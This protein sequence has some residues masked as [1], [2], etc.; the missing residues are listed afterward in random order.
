MVT[1]QQQIE[2]LKKSWAEDSRWNG[3][4][5][6]YAAEDV[7][8]LR[9]SVQI[10]YTLA[11]R[12]A[13]RLFRSIHERDFVNALGALTGN[14]AVQQVK[15]GLQAIYLSGWQVAA[16]ANS[17]GQMYPDQSLY[18]VDSV[19]NVVKKINQAL[20][21]AD[22]IDNVEG[23]EGFDWF[24]PIVA[25]AE[26]GFGGPLNVFE[27]MKSMIEA[28][29]AG[30]HFEDQLASEKKCGHLGGKVLQPTQNAV[31]N[32][33]SARLASDV[34]G[35]PTVLIARTDADAADLITSDID[36]VDHPFITGER[37]PEGF[38][39]TNAG[40]DQAIARGLAYAPYADLVW[41]ET[42][43]PNL[44]EAQQFADAIHEKFPGKLLAYNCSPSFNW[45]AKLDEETIAKYQVELGKMGYKFQFV[46]LAGFHALNHSMFELA[47]DYK[48]NGMAAY[49]KLQQ[50]EFESE[51]KGYTATRHQREVGTGYFD[52]VSQIISGGTSSTTAMKGSTETAQFQP[53]K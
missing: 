46:T 29:A 48:D 25:D 50:A 43:H 52:E 18:P 51:S 10:E 34:L 31:R 47:Y 39:R 17:A 27:L 6:P 42:S 38:Y 32:L 35:V 1:K 30:V 22:Q 40:I 36:P 12:G 20:Q 9:G 28:G 19:P 45:K 26:A 5:R 41:C 11:K 7:V 4:V 13:D 16:D 14:Q 8:K 3:I 49:S 23:N 21:R 37:T 53:V 44:E 15:A 33:I 2:E 24:A